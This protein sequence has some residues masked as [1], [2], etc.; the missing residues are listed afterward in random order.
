MSLSLLL[1][2]A[3]YELVNHA[4]KLY[5]IVD[6][7]RVSILVVPFQ[8]ELVAKLCLQEL[9]IRLQH[10]EVDV[11]APGWQNNSIPRDLVPH[12]CV[13]FAQISWSA[14]KARA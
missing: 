9:G 2:Q 8:P 12:S 3:L 7:Q 11:T 14:P 4:I 13:P 6:E 10:V 5:R 1:W